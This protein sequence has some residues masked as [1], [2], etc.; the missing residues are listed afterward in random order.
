MANKKAADWLTKARFLGT[1]DLET[2]NYDND[3][4]IND[5]D[6]RNLKKTSGVQ[7]AAKKI[8]K[9]IEIWQEKNLRGHHNKIL[10]MI[11]LIQKQLSIIMIQA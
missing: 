8:V 6:N 7:I 1:D 11:L 5:L 2:I 9:N 3:T 4:N 10:L